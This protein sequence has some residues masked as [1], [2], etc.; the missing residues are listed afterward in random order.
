MKFLTN[1]D[2]NQNEIQNAI[3]QPLAAAPSNPKLG[4][5]YFSSSD[6]LLYQYDGEQ[7]KPVGKPYEL[8]AATKTALGGVKAGDRMTVAADGTLSADKQTD[9]NL[10]N[11]LKS[12]YDAAHEHSQAAHAPSDAEKNVQSDWNVTDATSDAFIKNK[13]AIPSAAADVGAISA[14]DKGKAGGVA[15]LDSGGKV[16]AAQLPSYVDDVVD[17]FIISGATALS[18]GWLSASNGGKAMTPEP[19]KIYVIVTAG[20]YE[21]QTFRW[22]GTVYA[23]V[24]NDLA[25]GETEHTAYRGDRGKAAY[26]HSQSAHAPA[27]AEQNVQSDWAETSE[28]SDAFIKNKPT[29]P[30]AVVKTIKSMNGVATATYTVNGYILSVTLIDSVTKEQIMGDVSFGAATAS[31]NSKVTV[32]FS[33]VPTNPV[34]VI[35]ASIEL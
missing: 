30:Q 34:L 33:T 4:Q 22:S 6:L 2:L 24:G 13:P 27:N 9:N 11:A 17:A 20:E 14:S 7:W 25:L 35:I 1:L 3:V 21:G 28:N 26:E 12:N 5:I 16:P 10:T 31:A 15:E 23:P 8:P 19:G 18:A 29:I 32:T